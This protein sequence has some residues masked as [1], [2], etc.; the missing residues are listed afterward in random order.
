MSSHNLLHFFAYLI[1]LLLFILYD[2]HQEVNRLYNIS[3]GQDDALIKYQ[4][5]IVSQNNYIKLLEAEYIN[6]A[7]NTSPIH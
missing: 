2:R 1:I 6:N 3:L 5:A 4:Q 7:H